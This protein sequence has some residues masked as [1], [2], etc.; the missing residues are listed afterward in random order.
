MFARIVY[1]IEVNSVTCLDA[2]IQR[3][4][5]EHLMINSNG[6][7]TDYP[8]M[9]ADDNQELSSDSKELQQRMVRKKRTKTLQSSF[10][11]KTTIKVY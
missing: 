4:I 9:T 5:M 8:W 2:E 3:S 10:G 1:F 7:E 11:R 6:K